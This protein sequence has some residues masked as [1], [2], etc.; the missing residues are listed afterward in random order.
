MFEILFPLSITL[1]VEV[2]I[3][4]LLKWRDLKL[5]I[6]ASVINLITNPL[7]NFIILKMGGT[8]TYYALFVACYEIGTVFVEALVVFLL[9]K[10]KFPMTLLFVFFANLLSFV[11]GLMFDFVYQSETKL[12]LFTLI[13]FALYMVTEILTLIHNI[14]K[15][16]ENATE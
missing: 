12:L 3:V 16:K 2:P 10:T 8:F 1:A 7:M 4:L 13:F 6:T 11:V 5:F 14:K 15:P 9:C